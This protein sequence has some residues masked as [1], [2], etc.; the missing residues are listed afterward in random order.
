MIVAEKAGSG[1]ADDLG[2]VEFRNLSYLEE[3]GWH[4]VDS[5]VSLKG[6]GM[7]TS[8]NIEN[9]YGVTAKGPNDIIAGSGIGV[10]R[11]GELLWTSG[12]VTLNVEVHPRVEFHIATVLGD[13]RYT[14][15]ASVSVPR[16]LDAHVSLEGAA[17]RTEGVL[18]FLG[19]ND[20]FQ[21]WTGDVSSR[22]QS[23]LVLMSRN[24]MIV[25]TWRSD[26]GWLTYS[27]LALGVLVAGV[28][29]L[30]IYKQLRKSTRED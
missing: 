4:R 29:G 21:G 25:A 16:G 5:L 6:C 20:N 27:L 3:D 23:V 28:I 11:N 26:L 19:V 2:P 17:I 9:P 15:N 18:G 1:K 22:N 8:C 24:K 7:N 30:K 13:Q 14:G 10:R 12:Y